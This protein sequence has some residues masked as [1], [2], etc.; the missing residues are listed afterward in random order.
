MLDWLVIGGGPHGVHVAARLID[1]ANVP[2]EKIRILDNEAMLLDRWKR[3]THNTGMQFLRSPSVHH[4]DLSSSSLRRFAKKRPARK[5]EKPFTRPY[6]RPALDLFNLHADE[7][8]KRSRLQELHI[9]GYANSLEVFDEGLRIGVSDANDSEKNSTIEARRVVLSLGAPRDPEWPEW[10]KGIAESSA[11]QGRMNAIEHI[12]APGF[13]LNDTPAP[14]SVAVVG[15]CISGAQVALRLAKAG[16]QV[17]LFSRHPLQIH[18]FDSEPGWQ[19]P[20]FMA[21]FSRIQQPSERRLRIQDARHRG[22]IPPDTHAALRREIADGRIEVLEKVEID[23]AQFAQG[24]IHLKAGESWRAFDRTVLATGFT[25]RPPGEE[26]LKEAIETYELPCAECGYPI[27]DRS[28][29]W[30]P[31]IFVTGPLAE[32]EIGPVSRNLSGAMRAGER[33]AA[34]AQTNSH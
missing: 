14:E 1:E 2:R 4:I 33:I 12:F 11:E 8:I 17:V 23:S 31:R 24:Q 28:L 15:G 10:A 5:I 29:R 16:S 22:S 13:E 25:G 7:M 6:D 32:L 18:Q 9:Q 26:W 27:V 19:G 20:K 21:G 3:C 30:H 34:V